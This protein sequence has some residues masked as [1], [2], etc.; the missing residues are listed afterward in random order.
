[1]PRNQ[2]SALVPIRQKPVKYLLAAKHGM[3]YL[4]IEY[5][6]AI[7]AHHVRITAMC[8][9][10]GGLLTAADDKLVK[11]W[12]FEGYLLGTLK[13]NVP[14]GVK[15]SSWNLKMD[16]GQY[17]AKEE[18]AVAAVLNDVVKLE[19]KIALIDDSLYDFSGLE[20]G[21]QTATF[22]RSELR[23]RI[24][25]SSKLLV[26]NF[27]SA[28]GGGDGSSTSLGGSKSRTVSHFRE[29]SVD[30]LSQSL[31][32][33]SSSSLL[34]KSNASI[35]SKSTTEALLE[36]RST[37]D[38]HISAFKGLNR[39]QLRRKN[40]T[41]ATISASYLE[42]TKVE[43]PMVGKFTNDL[44]QGGPQRMFNWDKKSD[45]SSNASSVVKRRKGKVSQRLL[46]T[47]A[48]N[49]AIEQSGAQFESFKDLEL[50]LSAADIK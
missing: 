17:I 15:S 14:L 25:L 39:D 16:I 19:E 12:S 11:M 13:Q 3:N 32:S 38:D 50:A 18:E 8:C 49:R 29:S 37:D 20:P 47:T 2:K 48:R 1:M 28:D 5:A 21:N 46:A 40:K 44:E 43:L 35:A 26:L 27:A 6:W 36:M 7:G 10:S 4:G 24:D 42:K 31:C 9:T 41:M 23:K 34:Q 45:Q 22:A 30:S 33:S